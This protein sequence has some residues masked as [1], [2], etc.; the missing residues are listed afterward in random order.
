[1]QAQRLMLETDEY[2]H[3]MHLPQL[4]ANIKIEAIF[5]LLEQP[6]TSIKR[7]PSVKL[8]PLTKNNKK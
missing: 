5:L 1:M 8:K 2:G 6:I 7:K 4:P 3:L